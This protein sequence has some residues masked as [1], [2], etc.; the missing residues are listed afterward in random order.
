M[1]N[2]RLT[3]ILLSAGAILLI[4]LIAMQFNSEVDWSSFDF[5]IMGILL[6]GSGL[7]I[8]FALRKFS[9]IRSRIIACG[10]I[11]AALFLIWAELSVGIIGTSFAGS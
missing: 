9:T 3:I 2:A 10:M 11:L 8:E 5:L 6:L 1:K 4:P 7:A